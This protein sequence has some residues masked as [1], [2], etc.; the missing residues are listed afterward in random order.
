MLECMLTFAASPKAPGSH[1]TTS[2]GFYLITMA[3]FGHVYETQANQ[4]KKLAQSYQSIY[5][6]KLLLPKASYRNKS[7]ISQAGDT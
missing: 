2:E 3:L 6:E 4:P 7:V 5:D 1:H